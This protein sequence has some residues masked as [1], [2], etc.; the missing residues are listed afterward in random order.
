[1]EQHPI[2]SQ[3]SSYQFKLVGDMTLKQFLQLATG[4]VIALIIYATKLHP[5]IKWPLIIFFTLLGIGMAFFP[6]EGRPL[7]KWIV[8]FFKS[9]YSP[10]IYKWK[11]SDV[12]QKFYKEDAPTPEHNFVAPKGEVVLEEYLESLPGRG[13]KAAAPLEEAEKTFLKRI[14]TLYTD[15]TTTPKPKQ[16]MPTG[17]QTET[18]KV[19]NMFL[20][21]KQT[22]PQVEKRKTPINVVVEEQISPGPTVSPVTPTLAGVKSKDGV[23]ARF[24]IDAAPPLPPERPNTLSGQVMDAEG[25]II[26]G[27][28]LEIKD[29]AG[30]P[31]RAVKTNKAGHFRIVTPLQNGKYEI[32][33]EKQGFDFENVTFMAENNI[34]PPIAVRAKSKVAVVEQ[35]QKH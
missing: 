15:H 8:A 9:I 3:V 19:G 2:P 24:S 32:L 35:G 29:V 17:Q 26:E 13:H 22:K 21:P 30:R 34:I 7:E 27:A 23:Q 16:T 18:S 1:M 31:V 25:K 10:T 11:K 4:V 33:S 14:D 20:V 12:A 28:I 6:I 5:I